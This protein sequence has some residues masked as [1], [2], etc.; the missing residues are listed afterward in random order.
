MDRLEVLGAEAILGM[1]D[2]GEGAWRELLGLVRP[3]LDELTSAPLAAIALQ[4][5]TRATLVHQGTEPLRL[6]LSDLAMRANQRRDG[7]SEATW[8]APPADYG[9]VVA[10][11]GWRLELPFEHG[12]EVR[13][14]DRVTA[15]VTFA[16]HDGN[17]LL[18]V[19]LLRVL[20]P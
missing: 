3:L 11:P 19:S 13:S 8:S 6:D 18:P 20:S 14:S 15:D 16:A 10:T 4:L 7:L 9:E 1:R 5:N 17:E 12:F 2:A